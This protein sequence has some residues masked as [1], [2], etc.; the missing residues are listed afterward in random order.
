MTYQVLSIKWRPQRFEEVVGQQH[1]AVTL[2]NSIRQNRLAHAYLFTGPRGVGKTTTARILAKYLNCTNPQDSNPCNECKNC[3][4]ITAGRSFD[5][6]EIDGASNN[7]VENIRDLRE[8]VKYPP[9]DGQYKIYIIDEVHM[10]STS[11]FNALL[12]TLEEPP[13]H[14]KFIFATTE[15]ERVLPTIISRTQRFDFKR[16]PLP[17]I[18]EQLQMICDAEDLSISQGALTLIARKA[19]GSMRDAE[20]LLD[21]VISFS[22][23]DIT[24]ESVA[25]VLGVVDYDIYLRLTEIQQGQDVAGALEL[26]AGVMESGYDLGEFLNGL[27]DFWRNLLVIQ[28]ADKPEAGLVEVPESYL[29]QFAGAAGGYDSRDLLRLLNLTLAAQMQFRQVRNQR[30][31]LE[32]FLLKLVHFDRSVRLDDLL[33]ED[34]GGGNTP[35][36]ST[37]PEAPA[38]NP[39]KKKTGRKTRRNIGQKKTKIS[40]RED[41]PEESPRS[42]TQQ[43]PGPESA[44]GQEEAA[45]DGTGKDIAALQQQWAPFTDYVKEK[46]GLLGQFL[47]E[48]EPVAARGKVLE[49]LFDESCKFHMKTVVEKS[50]QVE[51]FIRDYFHWDVRLKCRVGKTNKPQ[52]PGESQIIGDPITQA[53]I[54]HFD[55]EIIR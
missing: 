13:A 25:S 32:N 17:V 37:S 49:V 16:I 42:A 30:I 4:E 21:Q 7:G 43:E 35:R 51:N 33:G 3:R 11:A 24:D 26:L 40:T 44:A 47:S 9:S 18:R 50:A 39:G 45:A 15:P 27:A 36:E 48:C 54:N 41:P 29:E 34:G 55:G 38:P 52:E 19:D 5:V 53:I 22:G 20:S 23:Q 46:T 31:F 6:L 1:V 2:Q 14:V 8:A 12:K 28:A 10:L